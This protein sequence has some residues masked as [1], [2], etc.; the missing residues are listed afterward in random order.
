MEIFFTHH[1]KKVYIVECRILI[2]LISY[3]YLCCVSRESGK[4]TATFLQ[5]SGTQLQH[6]PKS[7][8]QACWNTDRWALVGLRRGL[9]IC[10]SK[11]L[12]A[13][14]HWLSN[15]TCTLEPPGNT[16]NIDAWVSPPESYLTGI[17]YSLG[18]RIF[19]SS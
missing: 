4:G 3:F 10:I 9:R 6:I 5:I 1:S 17:E 14:Y 15:V 11:Y 12:G 18:M 13:A 16:K 19:L 8:L 7:H 2:V